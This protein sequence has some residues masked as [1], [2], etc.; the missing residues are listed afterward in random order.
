MWQRRVLGR[1]CNSMEMHKQRQTFETGI[2]LAGGDRLK[3]LHT[4]HLPTDP[5]LGSQGG[6]ADCRATPAAFGVLR[7]C[8]LSGDAK[9]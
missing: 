1:S 9:R 8:A 7:V 4:P 5:W 6:T 3:H 2:D